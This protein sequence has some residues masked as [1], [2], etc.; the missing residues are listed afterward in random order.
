MD[1]VV[2]FPPISG[3]RHCVRLETAD[4]HCVV[5]VEEVFCKNCHQVGREFITWIQVRVS[6]NDA[7]SCHI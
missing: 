7:V 4:R 2:H 3:G 6:N 1:V 5:E